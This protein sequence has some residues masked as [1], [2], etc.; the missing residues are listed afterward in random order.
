MAVPD[1]NA[2]WLDGVVR[3]YQRVDVN[4][5]VGVGEGLRAPVLIDVAS[6]SLKDVATASATAMEDE[7]P[8]L[9]GTMTVQN[10]GAF[11]LSSRGARRAHAPGAAAWRSGPSSMPR[12]SSTGRSCRSPSSRRR[13]RRTTGSSTARSGRPGW[14]RCGL[15]SGGVAGQIGRRGRGGVLASR[16]P[17]AAGSLFS[18]G[19]GIEKLDH[20]AEARRVWLGRLSSRRTSSEAKSQ[21]E[22][23]EGRYL[24]PGDGRV[25]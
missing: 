18:A 25:R 3:Q 17:P 12:R 8:Y 5:V 21:R 2:S 19:G 14:R 6:M 1:V 7:S 23:L 16:A 22:P 20:L 11:G 13:S 15:S 4:L 10:L 24:R 9:A